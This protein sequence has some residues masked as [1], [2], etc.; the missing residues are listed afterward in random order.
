MG[1]CGS[2][3]VPQDVGLSPLC[4]VDIPGLG[5]CPLAGLELGL[6]P[7]CAICCEAGASV[8]HGME[9]LWEP[10]PGEN[11]ADAVTF[12][13]ESQLCLWNMDGGENKVVG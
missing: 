5:L 11:H 4:D 10:G 13:R 1:V 9:S 8:S 6:R 2:T 12:A 7:C 3:C